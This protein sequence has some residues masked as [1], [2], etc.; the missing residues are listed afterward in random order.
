MIGMRIAGSDEVVEEAIGS[1]SG[2]KI[3][4]GAG[5]TTGHGSS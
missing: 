1:G 5:K 4:G 3:R 2:K